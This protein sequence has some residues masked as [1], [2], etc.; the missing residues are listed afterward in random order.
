MTLSSEKECLPEMKFNDTW[1]QR[2]LFPTYVLEIQYEDRFSPWECKNTGISRFKTIKMPL[3]PYEVPK[4]TL[5]L[6]GNML[7]Y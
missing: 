7:L 6:D 3:M 5:K 1:D 2:L 4:H